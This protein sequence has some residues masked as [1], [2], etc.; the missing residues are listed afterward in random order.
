MK[1]RILAF[2]LAWTSSLFSQHRFSWQD[3]CFK[4]PAAP[5][6]Q[7]HE[8]FSAH[9]PKPTEDPAAWSA[10]TDMGPYPATPEKVTPSVIVVGSIDWRFADPSADALAGADCTKLAGSPLAHSLI[11]QLGANQ[12]LREPDMQ[13]IFEALS[14]VSRVALAVRE[15]RIAIMVTGRAADSSLPA[16]EAGWKGTPVARNALLIAHSEA[17]DQAIQRISTEGL[18][19]E[20]ARIARAAAGR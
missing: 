20:L 18:V 2:G 17:V 3:A 9:P 11:A 10:A 7:G 5:Y 8:F 14:A 1:L 4:N 12:G 15:N 19:G 6:C 16:L 13:K